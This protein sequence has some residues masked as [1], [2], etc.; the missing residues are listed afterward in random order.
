MNNNHTPI[1]DPPEK[2]LLELLS[3]GLTK[4]EAAGKLSMSKFTVDSHLRSVFEKLNVHNT[5]AAV[6]EAMRRGEME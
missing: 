4:E 6:A 5:V 1:L 2:E 3:R